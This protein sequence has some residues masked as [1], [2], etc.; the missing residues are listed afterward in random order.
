MCSFFLM[1][2][3]PPGYTRTYTLFP[4]TTL[5]RSVRRPDL[6]RPQRPEVHPGA[7]DREHDRSQVWRIRADPHV[8]RPCRRQ[9][10]EEGLSM[11]KMKRERTLA[12]N[13]A[14]AFAKHLKTSPQKLNLVAGRIRGTKADAALAD[15]AFSHNRISRAVRTGMQ[16]DP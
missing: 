11:G 12:E 10:G 9:E 2:L 8:S 14:K 6:R 5:F 7:G 13:E 15:P 1:V 4:Y 16:P 3:P